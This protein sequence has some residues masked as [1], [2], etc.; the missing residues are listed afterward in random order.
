[1]ITLKNV[2]GIVLLMAGI[3]MLFTPG[4][5]ILT[6]LLGLSFV[7]FPGKRGL[8]RRIVGNPVVLDKI[9]SLRARANRPPLEI[10]PR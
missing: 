7:D 9:N 8:E 4:Q 5:G 6:I 10:S 2:V 1:L 3:V